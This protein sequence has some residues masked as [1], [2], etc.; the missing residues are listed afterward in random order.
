MIQPS[1]GHDPS[2]LSYLLPPYSTVLPLVS[3]TG[4]TV[5]GIFR[6]GSENGP[7][8][9]LAALTPSGKKISGGA[10]YWGATGNNISEKKIKWG[11]DLEGGFIFNLDNTSEKNGRFGIWV[12]RKKRDLQTKRK[13]KKNRNEPKHLGNTP[14]CRKQRRKWA[15]VSG[16]W[17]NIF[18]PAPS[19]EEN[20]DHFFLAH[21]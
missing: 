19:A 14:E 20:L 15:S 11:K 3:K 7:I 10:Q 18:F 9:S 13:H 17:E 4:G 1:S 16:E 6:G 21:F 5:G 8:F 12:A 2:I